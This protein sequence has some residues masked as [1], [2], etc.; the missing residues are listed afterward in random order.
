MSWSAH[1]NVWFCIAT[2]HPWIQ[3]TLSEIFVESVPR[4][5]LSQIY[6]DIDPC[7]P[8]IVTKWCSSRRPG[9][10]GVYRRLPCSKILRN[11][12]PSLYS[13]VVATQKQYRTLVTTTKLHELKFIKLVYAITKT[14]TLYNDYSMKW[15]INFPTNSYMCSG[16]C[17]CSLVYLLTLW[18]RHCWHGMFRTNSIIYISRSA[19]PEV[20]H[21]EWKV[22]LYLST[23]L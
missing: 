5:S 11:S 17:S 1:K 19:D 22:Y 20:V 4:H 14:L 23:A 9:R 21:C 2:K 16:I 18:S 6:K 7:T 10:K 8:S 3:N 13:T 12:V 15:D